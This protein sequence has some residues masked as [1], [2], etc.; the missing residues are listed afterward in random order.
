M[1]WASWRVGAEDNDT[2]ALNFLVKALDKAGFFGYTLENVFLENV[3][4]SL[5][6]EVVA[7]PEEKH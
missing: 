1:W 5:L 2:I 7:F 6:Y 4:Q 3:F